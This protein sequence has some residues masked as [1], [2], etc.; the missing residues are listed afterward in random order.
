NGAAAGSSSS[1]LQAWFLVSSAQCGIWC[2]S[3]VNCF[4]LR[5]S[6][7]PVGGSFDCLL[8]S[9][10]SPEALTTHNVYFSFDQMPTPETTEGQQGSQVYMPGLS[11]NRTCDRKVRFTSAILPLTGSWN[12]QRGSK[13][14]TAARYLRA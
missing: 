1:N 13:K 6:R 2:A 9:G 11:R 5:S 8:L 10:T 7:C 12:V 4:T 14:N 3:V